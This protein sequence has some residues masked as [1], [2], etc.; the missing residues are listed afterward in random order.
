MSSSWVAAFLGDATGWEQG[1]MS[2]LEGHQHFTCIRELS[3][4]NLLSC[5]SVELGKVRGQHPPA[6]GLH[7]WKETH[8]LALAHVGLSCHIGGIWHVM[9]IK[10]FSHHI[11][12]YCKYILQALLALGFGNHLSFCLAM[13][14]WWFP[15]QTFAEVAGP[16]QLA[17]TKS[18][19]AGGA[20][21]HAH[22]KGDG[23]MTAV[24][25]GGT[26][27]GSITVTGTRLEE[28]SSSQLGA[29]IPW[30]DVHYLKWA[31]QND[32]AKQGQKCCTAA[33]KP[34]P[35]GCLWVPIS[36]WI[37]VGI[38]TPEIN[39]NSSWPSHCPRAA[40]TFPLPCPTDVYC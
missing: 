17:G 19:T 14:R 4:L 20:D 39:K 2:L 8:E 36:S 37:C 16:T 24:E 12:L 9:V 11:I 40:L 29:S 3:H 23:A 22:E 7:S 21:V 30:W 28:V 5:S 10:W 34:A 32:L 38:Q 18:G 26:G 35:V 31:N 33:C 13:K 1:P 27:V 25:R 6:H 15:T